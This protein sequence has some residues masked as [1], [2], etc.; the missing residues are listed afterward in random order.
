VT[1]AAPVNPVRAA[2]SRITSLTYSSDVTN[3]V[4]FLANVPYAVLLQTVNTQ[5]LTTATWTTLQWD[6]PSSANM[7]D[8][9]G[10]YSPGASTTR[11]TVT[12]ANNAGTY[13]I[14]G[15]ANFALNSSGLRATKILKN[16]TVIQGSSDRRPAANVTGATS[17]CE[18][19]VPMV[20]NDYVEIQAYQSSGGNLA[21]SIDSDSCSSM[22]IQWFHE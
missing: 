11:W 15:L 9:Y 10:G 13:R 4:N 12:S 7:I 20:L 5:T 21:T 8:P 22:L 3:A 17:E 16:G 18:W 19:F 1:L 6:N 2:G 14:R